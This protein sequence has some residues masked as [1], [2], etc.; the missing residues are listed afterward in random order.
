MS[1]DVSPYQPF[2]EAF[3]PLFPNGWPDLAQR[4]GFELPKGFRKRQAGRSV[5]LHG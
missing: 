3:L 5:R 2:A 4:E 1:T